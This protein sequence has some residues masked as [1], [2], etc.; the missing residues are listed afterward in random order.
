M[1]KPNDGGPAFPGWD[2]NSSSP[3]LGMSLRDWFAGMALQGM[4]ACP[5]SSGGDD[6][7]EVDAYRLADRMIAEREKQ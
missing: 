1:S 4:L 3:I 5:G 6:A 2:E 7:Y